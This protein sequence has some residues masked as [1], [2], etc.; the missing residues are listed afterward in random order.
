MRTL[1]L[2]TSATLIT[3]LVPF[4]LIMTSIRILFTPF[5]V[6]LE[7][8]SPG[9]PDDPY[10]FTLE[11]RLHWS[12]VSLEYLLN[13]AE[14]NYLA[15][16][17][18]PDGSPLYNERELSH[19]LDVKI[20]VQ[21]MIRAWTG[22]LLIM[23]VAGMIAW[24]LNWISGFLRALANGG[25]LT[26]ALIVIILVA[27]AISFRQLFTYFHMLFF[28]GDTWLFNYSDNL[29]RLF[30]MRFWQDGFIAMGVITILGAVILILIDHKWS[31]KF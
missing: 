4:L 8:R 9:F 17:R 29:I 2:R 6:Q 5:F 3:V 24:R 16:Q 1:I 21:Q 14:I 22:L 18:L 15:D 23:I 31:K 25:K 11:D 30:P 27:V 26:L 13:N 12:R 28:V 20:L 10:G 7:Y 19:M